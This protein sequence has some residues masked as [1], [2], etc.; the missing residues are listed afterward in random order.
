MLAKNTNRNFVN[1]KQSLAS[2]A[3]GLALS[4]GAAGIAQADV[5]FADPWTPMPEIGLSLNGAEPL[6]FEPTVSDWGSGLYSYSLTSDTPEWLLKVA[7]TADTDL[8]GNASIN[9]FVE[10]TNKTSDVVNASFTF[11][12][13]LCPFAKDTCSIGATTIVKL[14]MDDG[15]GE[16]TCPEGDSLWSARV[17]QEAAAKLFYGP[18]CM[19]GTGKGTAST[20]ASFGAPY[21]AMVLDQGASS[22]GVRYCFG[23][24]G[25]DKVRFTNLYMVGANEADI[26]DCSDDAE[27]MPGD[28]TGDGVVDGMDLGLLISSWGSDDPACDLNADGIVDGAD[29][30]ELFANWS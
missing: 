4:L 30:G 16:L 8:Y 13:P 28:I 26:V 5:I 29:L 21:P 24:T 12:L 6:S 18:F 27:A 22:F 23:L 9:G 25:N 19:S 10:F 15:G 11:D 17:D 1:S 2:P 14:T 7:L 3:L 20:N